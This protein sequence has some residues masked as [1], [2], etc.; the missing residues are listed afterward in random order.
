MCFEVRLSTFAQWRTGADCTSRRGFCIWSYVTIG[1][2]GLEDSAES[3]AKGGR[4]LPHRDD[5]PLARFE[6][7]TVRR[8]W[9]RTTAL[10]NLWPAELDGQVRL[11]DQ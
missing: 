3:L 11:S 5:G 7:S 8:R 1:G 10:A 4:E 2:S 9:M 6:I